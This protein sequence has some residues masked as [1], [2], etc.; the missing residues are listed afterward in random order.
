MRVTPDSLAADIGDEPLLLARRT[1]APVVVCADRV[2]GARLLAA[3]GAD[4]IVADDGLQHYALRR[5]LEI[6][7]VDGERRFGNGRLLPAG[8]LREPASRLQEAAIVLANGGPGEAHWPRFDLRLGPA[9]RLAGGQARPLED[10]AGRPAWVVAGIGNP[11][12]FHAALRHLGIE[13]HAVE[14]PDHGRVELGSLR[15]D[16]PW[17]VLMTEKDAVKYPQLAEPDMWFVPAEVDMQGDAEQAVLSKVLAQI[18]H[19][20]GP[21][22]APAAGHG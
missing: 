11:G 14:V 3:E 10:F 4:V 12:R 8:P 19:G 17:P 20:R 5:D 1:G 2:R 6:V 22:V 18:T 9:Q 16:E 7:V 13:V 21:A 15:R